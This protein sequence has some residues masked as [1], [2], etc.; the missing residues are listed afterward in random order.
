M[1]NPQ[2]S[3]WLYVNGLRGSYRKD[4]ILSMFWYIF[5]YREKGPKSTHIH[6][7]AKSESNEEKKKHLTERENGKEKNPITATTEK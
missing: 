3:L 1:K 6:L 4:T 7:N 5:F 2:S